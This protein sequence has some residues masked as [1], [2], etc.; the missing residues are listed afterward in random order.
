ME[1]DVVRGARMRD[2]DR[3]W[4]FAVVLTEL[5]RRRLGLPATVHA[6]R[7]DT[8]ICRVCKRTAEDIYDH[9]GVP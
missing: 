4:N 5:T 3:W 6:F 8:L 1:G 2:E 9:P 7:L